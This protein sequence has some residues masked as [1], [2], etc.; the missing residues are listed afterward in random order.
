MGGSQPSIDFHT[1]ALCD[2]SDRKFNG[3]A[4]PAPRTAITSQ[5]SGLRPSISRVIVDLEYEG[6][7]F[8]LVRLS[9]G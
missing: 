1:E 4:P 5:M 9:C 3:L 7:S 6:R 2:T 8:W